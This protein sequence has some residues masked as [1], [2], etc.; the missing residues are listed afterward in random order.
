M[1]TPIPGEAP[2]A[3]NPYAPGSQAPSYP[4]ASTPE[5][6]Q[7]QGVFGQDSYEQRE[8]GQQAYGQQS[9]GQ[10]GYGQTG[11]SQAAYGQQAPGQSYDQAGYDQ[12]GY[13]QAAY[14]QSYSQQQ[15][16][17]QPQPAYVHGAPKQMIIA[18]LLALVLGYLGVHNFY[19]GHTNRGII[20]LILTITFIGSF[21][22]MI[23]A[24]VEFILILMRSGQY[25]YDARGVPLA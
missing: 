3:S 9:Y 12:A 14:G 15:A 22:S 11:Y 23:W 5:G 16:W 18:A 10:A 1:T 20:Q 8:Y 19:L 21:I 24:F 17:T 6:A 25:A 13:D 4:Q 7:T 2:E